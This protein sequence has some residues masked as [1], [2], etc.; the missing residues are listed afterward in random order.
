MN[1]EASHYV[2]LFGGNTIGNLTFWLPLV[3]YFGCKIGKNVSVCESRY[4]TEKLQP[5]QNNHPSSSWWKFCNWVFLRETQDVVIAEATIHSVNISSGQHLKCSIIVSL[6]SSDLNYSSQWDVVFQR[7]NSAYG[8]LLNLN[9][10]QRNHFI[11]K[12]VFG[13]NEGEDTL[14]GDASCGAFELRICKEG[15]PTVRDYFR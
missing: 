10:G 6:G 3:D 14:R 2:K 13:W 1:K 8:V 4:G 5:G 7:I 15:A 9:C 11:H 12:A